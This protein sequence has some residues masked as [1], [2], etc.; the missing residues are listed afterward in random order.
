MG[1]QSASEHA[2]I[3]D[4]AIV[5]P[6]AQIGARVEIGPYAR[7]EERAVVGD[8]T[9][10][11]QGA[12]IGRG[13]TIGRENRIHPYAVLGTPPQDVGYRGE[14]T[15]LVVG[16]RNVFREFFTANRGTSKGEGTTRIGSDGMFMTCS[17]VA[18]DCQVGDRVIMANGVLLGGHVHVG[19]RAVM[20]GQAAAHHFTRIG[21]LAFV[22][23][24]S[25]INH[26]V[27][28]FL[29]TDG[30]PARVHGPNVV[31]LRRALVP[32]ETIRALQLAFR[33]LWADEGIPFARGLE[34]LEEQRAGFP[35]IGEL[36]DFLRERTKSPKGRFLETLRKVAV[37]PQRKEPGASGAGAGS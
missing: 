13:A 33:I 1:D 30:A 21:R 18:H 20:G 4:T 37:V 6:T 15:R 32:E 12:V 29:I 36:V 11:G 28:P 31:G 17:H 10:V 16:D 2:R 5:H 27:P 24:M 22:G 8:G 25:R 9:W 35:E 7:I 14:D 3:H 34:R 23:G 19:D 26:D